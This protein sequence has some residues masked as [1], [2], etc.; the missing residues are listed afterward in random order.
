MRLYLVRKGDKS[1]KDREKLIPLF[2]DYKS[3]G[4][5]VSPMNTET[6]RRYLQEQVGCEIEPEDILW[7]IYHVN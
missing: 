7:L 3:G 4:G 5:I 6:C 2:K 1:M